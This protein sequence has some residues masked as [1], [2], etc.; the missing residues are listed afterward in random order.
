MPAACRCRDWRV[1]WTAPE[2][3]ASRDGSAYLEGHPRVCG[4]LWTATSAND[5]LAL[6]SIPRIGE[7]GCYTFPHIMVVVR[8]RARTADASC[9]DCA[10]QSRIIDTLV[11]MD[12]S[13]GFD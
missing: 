13:L 3:Q 1:Q 2:R 8:A 5:S 4:G 6:E 12:N 7:I 10:R 9:K 11:L